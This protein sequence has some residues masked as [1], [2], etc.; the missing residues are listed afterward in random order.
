MNARFEQVAND[1]GQDNIAYLRAGFNKAKGV[2]VALEAELML[3]AAV[4]GHKKDTEYFKLQTR[5]AGAH[6]EV[7]KAE[8][9]LLAKTLSQGLQDP[10]Q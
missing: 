4:L 9:K 2:H 5:K 3:K 7:V 6:W 1:V 8:G 10:Q